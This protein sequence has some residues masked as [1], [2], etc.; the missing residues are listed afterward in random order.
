M[1][2]RCSRR[3]GSGAVGRSD[4]AQCC[5]AVRISDSGLS[6]NPGADTGDRLRSIAAACS[7]AC[8]VHTRCGLRSSRSVRPCTT[9][10]QCRVGHFEAAFSARRT[11]SESCV[12][13]MSVNTWPYPFRSGLIPVRPISNAPPS[14]T[15]IVPLGSQTIARTI[16]IHHRFG[17]LRARNSPRERASPRPRVHPPGQ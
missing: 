11:S 2:K 10:P 5:P 4:A 14:T 8:S 6:A 1:S 13:A 9:R 16:S 17:C 3:T 12:P 7:P 15:G